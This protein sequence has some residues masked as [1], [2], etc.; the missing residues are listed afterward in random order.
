MFR[1][2]TVAE[3]VRDDLVRHHA[4]MPGVGQ[5]AQPINATY[6]VEESLHAS[7]MMAILPC[8]FKAIRNRAKRP[9]FFMLPR[10]MICTHLAPSLLNPAKASTRRVRPGYSANPQQ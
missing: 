3:R 9:E 8:L 6:R 2:K 5:S 4:T 7:M 1:V 10:S